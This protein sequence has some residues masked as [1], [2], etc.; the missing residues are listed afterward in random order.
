MSRVPRQ[1]TRGTSLKDRGMMCVT[2]ADLTAGGRQDGRRIPNERTI[3]THSPGRPLPGRR[4]GTPTAVQ[5][6]STKVE[7]TC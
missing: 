3:V 7:V 4:V 6:T 1:K 2:D 5:L